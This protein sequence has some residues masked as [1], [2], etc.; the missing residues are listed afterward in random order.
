MCDAHLNDG[1]LV[2]VLPGADHGHSHVY[3]SRW[4]DDAI[5]D[6]EVVS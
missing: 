4:A 6:E 3:E 2:C 5:K 1:P